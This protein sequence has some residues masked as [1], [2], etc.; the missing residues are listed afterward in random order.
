MVDLCFPILSLVVV[1]S[2]IVTPGND[3]GFGMM[4]RLITP[5]QKT[6]AQKYRTQ[7]RA[8][9]HLHDCEQEPTS[10]YSERIPKTT[11]KL[12]KFCNIP[13]TQWYSTNGV[14]PRIKMASKPS[15]SSA[16]SSSSTNQQ[17]RLLLIPPSDGRLRGLI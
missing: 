7:T 6:Q 4:A 9:V 1:V 13:N 15:A 11:A 17:P 5:L 2:C 8:W 16:T 3:F 14:F 10:Q 12:T